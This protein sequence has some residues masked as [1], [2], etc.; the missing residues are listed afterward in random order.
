MS[1]K[2]L[3]LFTFVFEIPLF[4]VHVLLTIFDNNLVTHINKKVL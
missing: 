3:A 1:I 4:H 2:T